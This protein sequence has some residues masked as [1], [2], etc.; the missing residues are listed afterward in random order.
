[1]TTVLDVRDLNFVKDMPEASTSRSIRFYHKIIYQTNSNAKLTTDVPNLEFTYPAEKLCI[2][3]R[4]ECLDAFSAVCLDMNFNTL[5]K[6]IMTAEDGTY[7]LSTSPEFLKYKD[8]LDQDF[9]MMCFTGR[10]LCRCRVRE[11]SRHEFLAEI[12]HFPACDAC[13]QLSKNCSCCYKFYR[14][15]RYYK[16]QVREGKV[17]KKLNEIKRLAYLGGSSCTVCFN[18]SRIAKFCICDHSYQLLYK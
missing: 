18:C 14:L 15:F 17:L 1:M 4:C 10:L 7:P 13:L 9:C 8:A 2:T 3:L 12:K 6:V 11:M 16:R 5:C